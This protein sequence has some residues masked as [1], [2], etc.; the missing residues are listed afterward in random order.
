MGNPPRS[1]PCHIE[2]GFIVR[3]SSSILAVSDQ[4]GFH[5][6]DISLDGKIRLDLGRIRSRRVSESGVLL[7]GNRR[8]S[9]I[10]AVLDRGGFHGRES[11]IDGNPDSS[12]ILAMSD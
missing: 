12:S 4:G 1:W 6:R 9:S 8:S 3:S 10:L 5:S 11:F 2:A 7:D